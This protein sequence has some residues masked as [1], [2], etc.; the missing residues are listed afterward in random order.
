MFLRWGSPSPQT[1][2][3]T[4]G[5][6]LASTTASSS[7]RNV[8]PPHYSSSSLSAPRPVA[9]PYSSGSSAQ[10]P[11][12]PP[13]ITVYDLLPSQIQR[14]IDSLSLTEPETDE[15]PVMANQRVC[16]QYHTYVNIAYSRQDGKELNTNPA[17]VRFSTHMQIN[18]TQNHIPTEESRSR[19]DD[20]IGLKMREG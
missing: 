20:G 1:I 9:P 11:T 5:P 3:I 12:L 14:D 17:K 10:R 15:E 19:K 13:G 16:C 6:L 2:D 4:L 18:I 8:A 7:N